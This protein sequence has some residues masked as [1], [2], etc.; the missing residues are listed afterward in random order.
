MKLEHKKR[1]LL[2]ASRGSDAVAEA[3]LKE[4]GR[5]WRCAAAGWFRPKGQPKNCGKFI[6]GRDPALGR[7]CGRRRGCSGAVAA[8]MEK[9]GQ[10]G[11]AGEQCRCD[12][13]KA[14]L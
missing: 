11:R 5:G 6:R 8:V 7:G 3:F 13:G 1:P 4:G 14:D 9:M 10:A 12:L 2:P